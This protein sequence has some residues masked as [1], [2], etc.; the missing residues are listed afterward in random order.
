MPRIAI[1][2]ALIASN[3]WQTHKNERGSRLMLK[4]RLT[5]GI[6]HTTRGA[7]KDHLPQYMSKDKGHYATFDVALFPQMMELLRYFRRYTG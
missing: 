2:S 1:A 4:K 3:A 5:F 7:F 6:R